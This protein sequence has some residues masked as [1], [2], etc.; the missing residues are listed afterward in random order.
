[1]EMHRNNLLSLA[2]WKK[3]EPELKTEVERALEGQTALL[4]EHPDLQKEEHED[5]KLEGLRAQRAALSTMLSS[6]LLSDAVFEE[7]VT[8]VDESIAKTHRR[9][10]AKSE[11][12]ATV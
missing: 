12:P 6:G 10:S 4:E 2:T 3:I 5:A 8:E 9:A 11:E 1:E 7:L